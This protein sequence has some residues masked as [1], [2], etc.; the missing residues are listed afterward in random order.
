MFCKK[1]GNQ[2]QPD[3]KFCRNCGTLAEEKSKNNRIAKILISIIAVCLVAVIGVSSAFLIK[4]NKTDSEAKKA[5]TTEKSTDPQLDLNK[6]T[7]PSTAVSPFE[8]NDDQKQA[9][10]E[11]DTLQAAGGSDNKD[12]YIEEA[13]SRQGLVQQNEKVFHDVTPGA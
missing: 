7:V 13:A 9:A 12:A 3:E 11:R 1:C 4:N 6:Y 10:D 2:L 8:L 5:K